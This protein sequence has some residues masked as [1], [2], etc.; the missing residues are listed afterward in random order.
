[1]DVSRCSQQFFNLNSS[2]SLIH[3]QAGIQS[4]F[5]GLGPHLRED[6]RKEPSGV[7]SLTKA[8]APQHIAAAL[9]D[10]DHCRNDGVLI[11][12]IGEADPH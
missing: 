10:R 3:A 8:G 11:G 9:A 6:D 12:T 7:R 4:F 5:L 2:L 1:M